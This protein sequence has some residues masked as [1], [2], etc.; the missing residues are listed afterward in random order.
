VR[1][2]TVPAPLL[3]LG[4]CTSLQLGAAIATPL[5]HSLGPGLTV[6]TRL[7]LA[8]VLLIVLTRPP[9]RRWRLPQWRALVLFGVAMAGMNGLFFAAIT[10]LPLG[11]AVT[12][13]FLGPLALAAVLSRRRRE[14]GF[15]VLAAG[16]VFLLGL[17]S[18]P[19]TALDPLGVA[20]I[21]GAA[22]FWAAYILT[23]RSV[24]R[25]IEGHGVLGVGMGIAA[26]I[27]A[28]FGI[29]AVPALIT[30]PTY[31]LPLATVAVLSSVIPYSLEFVALRRLRPAVFGVLLALEPVVA[32]IIGWLLLQQRLGA[33][34]IA[35]MALV[36]GAA[37][38]SSWT[39]RNAPGD[40]GDLS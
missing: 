26:V 16:G 19:G 27:V 35:G 6:T 1:R 39:G 20:A 23:G 3:V 38:A 4:S 2:I 18:G 24:G 14:I 22:G 12:I 28:P 5:L 17:P 8:A 40:D 15:V 30:G 37:T 31:V 33:A 9:V 34:Q 25:R 10:R 7:L 36:V 11:I 13:Q 21:L 32:G 29:G